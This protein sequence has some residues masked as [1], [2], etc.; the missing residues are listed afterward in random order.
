MR[1]GTDS[2]ATPSRSGQRRWYGEDMPWQAARSLRRPLAVLAIV[3]L[4]TIVALPTL[5]ADPPAP[6][7]KP[8]KPEKAAKDPKTPI[9]VTGTVRVTTGAG[10]VAIYTLSSGGTTYQLDAGPA[11]FHGDKHPLK[12]FVGKSVK[13][14]GTRRAGST[15]IDV[16]TVDGKA[17]RASGKPPWAGGW[18][19]VGEAHPG[20]TVEKAERWEAKV[21]AKQEKFGVDCWPPG[22]CRKAPTAP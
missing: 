2:G 19:K 9:T 22:Q 8:A 20:W 1:A 18:K 4:A 21:K 14:D 7:E 13:I 15:E 10:G 5:A 16:A 11:W 6:T 12:A 3:A 17:L